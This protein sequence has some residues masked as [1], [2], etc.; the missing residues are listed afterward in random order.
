MVLRYRVELKYVS[1]EGQESKALVD[2][3][4]VILGALECFPSTHNCW[5]SGPPPVGM[6]RRLLTGTSQRNFSR[7]T[8]ATFD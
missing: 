7:G 8:V 6:N 3:G 5:I 1:Y 4:L 2:I